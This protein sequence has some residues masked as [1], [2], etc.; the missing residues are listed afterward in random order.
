MANTKGKI[1][2]GSAIV[3]IAGVTGAIIF[4]HYRKKNFLKKIYAKNPTDKSFERA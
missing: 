2:I 1:I 4:S 3:L